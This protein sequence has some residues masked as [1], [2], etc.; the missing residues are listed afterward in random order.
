MRKL[1][2]HDPG[3]QYSVPY[4]WFTTGLGYNVD[5]V[6]ERL[7]TADFDSWSLLLD[8]KNAASSR[9]A[10]SSSSIPRPTCFPPC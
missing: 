6:R 5:K 3:N 8:P 2:V 9:T 4:L 1:A 10:A 7:G